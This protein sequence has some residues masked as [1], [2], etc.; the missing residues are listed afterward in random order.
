MSPFALYLYV[1]ALG[2]GLLTVVVLAV[3]VRGLLV[4]K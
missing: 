4:K 2:A 3:F 1:V